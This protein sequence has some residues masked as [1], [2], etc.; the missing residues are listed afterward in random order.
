[1]SLNSNVIIIPT[2]VL[3]VLHDNTAETVEMEISR[4]FL[5]DEESEYT[6]Q[7]EMYH[8]AI[9]GMNQVGKHKE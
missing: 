6:E 5:F 9:H 3:G 1:M 4:V 2:L 7:Y 8:S